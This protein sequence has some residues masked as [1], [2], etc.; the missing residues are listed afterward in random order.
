MIIK[1][2]SFSGKTDVGKFSEQYKNAGLI[3]G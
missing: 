3:D 1:P 2:N